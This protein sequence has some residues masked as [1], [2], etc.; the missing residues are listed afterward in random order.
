MDAGTTVTLVISNGAKTVLYKFSRSVT[1]SDGVDLVIL[2]DANGEEIG[3]WRVT[4]SPNITV[5]GS[6]IKTSS[7]TIYYCNGSRDNV[8]SSQA[9]SFTP[10]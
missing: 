2:C 8:I 9:V 5:S 4:D 3:S 1:V 6:N 10:Q 7:G